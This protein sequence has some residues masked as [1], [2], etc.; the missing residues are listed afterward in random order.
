MI[1]SNKL[2]IHL[3]RTDFMYPCELEKITDGEF[4][5]K[6]HSTVY[7]FVLDGQV[8]IN[9]NKIMESHEF[10]SFTSKYANKIKVK[11]TAVIITRHGFNGQYVFGGPVEKQGRLCYINN[12]SDSLLVYPPRMGDPSLSLLQFPEG[13]VQDFHTHPSFRLGIIFRG[14]GYAESKD[15]KFDLTPGCVFCMEEQEVHR[16]VTEDEP[17]S[18]ISF[19]P[20]GDWG[21]TDHNHTLL[22][23]TYLK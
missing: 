1:I 6:E 15:Q 19:H 12:C 2:N 18:V 14:K 16:F 22:N 8:E 3:D 7:G 17:L 13:I 20:D 9:K 11:G 21:P 4:T 23:R 10:F 5:L